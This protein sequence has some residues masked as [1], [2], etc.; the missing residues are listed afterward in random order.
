MDAVGLPKITRIADLV[1]AAFG[2]YKYKILLLALLGFLGGIFEIVGINAIIPIFSIIDGGNTTDII[3]ETTK[4][5]FSY[6]DL[7]YTVRYL[8]IFIMVMFLVKAAA[9]FISRYISIRIAA[10]YEENTRSGLFLAMTETSWP[11]LAKQKAGHLDQ[12]LITDVRVGS[13]LLVHIGTFILIMTSLVVYGLLAMN[14]SFVVALLAFI[15]GGLISFF[16]SSLFKKNRIASAE[17]A[18][19]YK[20][21]A[22]YAN[23]VILGMKA[24]KSSL[25]EAPVFQKSLSYFSRMKALYIRV[26]LLKNFTDI[27]LQPVAILFILGIFAVFY[28]TQSLTFAS[29]AVIVYAINR[30]FSNIQ[31]AQAEMHMISSAIPHVISI[32][33]Y[34]EEAGRN[35]ETTEGANMFQFSR[36]LEF[37]GVSFS[38]D[39]ESPTLYDINFSVAQGEMLGLIGPSGAGKSTLVDLLLRLLRPQEGAILIDGE[40]IS[41]I[42][43]KEWRKNA[44]YVPQ[45]AFLI[46]DTIYNNIRFFNSSLDAEDIERAAKMANIYDFIM[47]LPKGFDTVVG[48]RGLRFSGGERQR[49]VLARAL[50]RQPKILILDEA[51]SALDGESETLIQKAI[52]KLKGQMTILVIAHRLSTVVN[53]DKLVVLE[54][55]RITETGTPDELLVNKQSYFSKVYNLR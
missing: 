29:F 11:H 45:E 2:Q 44:A 40:N 13:S 30:V 28:K 23:E 38:Y 24:I 5:I 32:L 19:N 10:D 39:T 12:V 8:V 43:L 20:D 48:E 25:A 51:T 37:K 27:V 22:H 14:V 35:K 9:Q 26:T 15:F 49:M 18:A 21:L 16:F 53:S 31:S 54:N 55:G 36:L 6:F 34:Q 52:E 7:P 46:N 42:S 4:K 3:S 50:A 41:E 33:S 47:S 17:M 1:K